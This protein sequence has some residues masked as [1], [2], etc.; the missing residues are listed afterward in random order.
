[1]PNQTCVKL[2][3]GHQTFAK[4]KLMPNRIYAKP[5]YAKPN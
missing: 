2:N 5:N 1:M 4:P 3:L